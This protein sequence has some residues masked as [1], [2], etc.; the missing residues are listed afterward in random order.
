MTQ[1]KPIQRIEIPSKKIKSEE[2]NSKNKFLNLWEFFSTK[3]LEGSNC[4]LRGSLFFPRKYPLT[5]AYTLIGIVGF[6]Y[7]INPLNFF[8][9]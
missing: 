9:K 5:F 2:S 7:I 4:P 6:I 8:Y 1:S 3:P